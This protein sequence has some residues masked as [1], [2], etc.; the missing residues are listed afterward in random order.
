VKYYR[1]E[2]GEKGLPKSEMTY[3]YDLQKHFVERKAKRRSVTTPS[4]HTATPHPP[5]STT[6]SNRSMIEPSQGPDKHSEHNNNE[7]DPPETLLLDSALML[8]FLLPTFTDMLISF[9]AGFGGVNR[10]R[11]RK[12]VPTVPPEFLAKLDIGN[13][14]ITKIY[15]DTSWNDE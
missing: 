1:A 14:H 12:Y 11:A 6:S 9:G 10:E 8:P 2:V 13:N 7:G 3:L 4:N 5:I 15:N